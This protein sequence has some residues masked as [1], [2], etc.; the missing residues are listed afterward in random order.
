M[1][2]SRRYTLRKKLESLFSQRSEIGQNVCWLH[3]V[4]TPKSTQLGLWI[5]HMHHSALRLDTVG[6]QAV[7]AIG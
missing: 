4:L 1:P 3:S 5:M 2:T 6:L 7:I